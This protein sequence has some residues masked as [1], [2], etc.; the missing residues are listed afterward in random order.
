[1]PGSGKPG[2][3][4]LAWRKENAVSSAILYLAI[5]A[6]WAGI[7]VPRWVRRSHDASGAGKGASGQAPETAPSAGFAGEA[8]V[9]AESASPAGDAVPAGAAVHEHDAVHE[10]GVA[11]EHGVAFEY[12]AAFEYGEV[13]SS[14]AAGEYETAVEYGSV[15]AY[16]VELHDGTAG[17]GDAGGGGWPDDDITEPVLTLRGRPLWSEGPGWHPLRRQDRPR[18]AVTREAALRARRRML[19]TLVTLTVVALAL[20]AES[21]APWWIIVPPAGMLGLLVL[22]LHEAARADAEVAERQAEAHVRAAREAQH[23]ARQRAT[24]ENQ[25]TAAPE[26]SAQIIDISAR[27]GDQLYDQYADAAVRAV[28]D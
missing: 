20:A 8:D 19:T 6:I 11:V 24:A 25:V 16:D 7:L 27:V 22:L 21:M 26:P 18:P 28:G 14:G 4:V 10:H 5:V 13:H 17:S 15:V 12:E 3:R 23:A 9:H 1:M 2:G